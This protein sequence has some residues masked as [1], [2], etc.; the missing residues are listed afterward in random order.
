[1]RDLRRDPLIVRGELGEEAVEMAVIA[2]H[3]KY[4]GEFEI[5][6]GPAPGT[7]TEGDPTGHARR[8]R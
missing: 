3:E 1:M 8:T 5:R 6:I 4:D 2:G 7:E